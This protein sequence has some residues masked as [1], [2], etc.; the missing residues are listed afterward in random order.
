MLSF[1]EKFP[2]SDEKQIKKTNIV[3][4]FIIYIVF[5]LK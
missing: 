3:Y 5:I 2:S 4:F 1:E